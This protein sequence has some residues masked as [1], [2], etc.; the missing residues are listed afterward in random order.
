MSDSIHFLITRDMLLASRILL[1]YS[2]RFVGGLVGE[3]PIRMCIEGCCHFPSPVASR[4]L[5]FV[6]VLVMRILLLSLHQADVPT[7]SDCTM[8]R[9]EQQPHV[10]ECLGTEL[11]MDWNPCGC[12][13]H[14]GSKDVATVQIS[15]V[16]SP[17]SVLC[18]WENSVMKL[19][20]SSPK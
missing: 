14:R 4:L 1:L 7:C 15:Y 12:S 18:T 13:A 6:D 2:I 19:S 8:L 20:F 11:S 5:M 16:V 9:H 10:A 3:M 17:H